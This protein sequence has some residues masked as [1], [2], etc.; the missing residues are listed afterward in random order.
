MPDQLVLVVAGTEAELL[1]RGLQRQ[2]ASAT[3]ARSDHLKCHDCLTRT[4]CPCSPRRASATRDRLPASA[5]C[6]SAELN[7]RPRQPSA[8]GHHH[9]HSTK[10]CDDDLRPPQLWRRVEEAV[11]PTNLHGLTRELPRVHVPASTP[12]ISRLTALV[13]QA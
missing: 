7:D 2:R 4:Q 13:V 12:E 10:R 6:A 11:L 3:E 1:E 5:C 9:K 8:G